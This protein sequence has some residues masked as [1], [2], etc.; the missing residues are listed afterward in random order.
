MNFSYD[1]IQR[2]VY[3]PTGYEHIDTGMTEARPP[4]TWLSFKPIDTPIIVRLNT[5]RSD[6]MALPGIWLYAETDF[7]ALANAHAVDS[8][9]STSLDKHMNLIA[10]EGWEIKGTDP[11]AMQYIKQR[12]A[13]LRAT[14]GITFQKLLTDVEYSLVLFGNAYLIKVPFKSKN[15]VPGMKLTPLKGQKPIGGIFTVHPARLDAV[16]DG[17]GN[18][19]HWAFMVIGA[20]WAT[21]AKD[22]VVQFK[23]NCPPDYTYGQP[24]YLP[25]LEDIRTYRQL[26]WL[27]V[28]LMNRYLHP[29][30]HVRKGVDPSGKHLY[31]VTDAAIQKTASMLES[32]SADGVFV[33][34]PDV[35]ISVKGMESQALRAGEYLDM[36]KDR[37]L[38]GLNTSGPAMGETKAGVRVTADTITASMHDTT[39]MFQR[40]IAATLNSDVIYYWLIEGGFDPITHP[41][42]AYFIYN[43][44]ALDED[45]KKRNQHI[46]EWF[47][48]ATTHEEYRAAIGRQPLTKK[49]IMED[50]YLG[51]AAAI[52]GATGTMLPQNPAQG[53]TD[54]RLRPVKGGGNQTPNTPTST[55]TAQEYFLELLL[56]QVQNQR[57]A[58]TQEGDLE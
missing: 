57:E 45:I 21:F 34:G 1:D 50:T 49:Q 7:W 3:L 5:T 40:R 42:C 29:L 44:V 16:L 55:K 53:N 13:L 20:Q 54:N 10:K 47:S 25:A 52:A 30:V 37:C 39:L 27:T 11:K 17:V 48:G 12:L 2:P 58:A 46:Q 18:L 4:S 15:P 31:Q 35:E 28:M 19:D 23:V 26:E 8:F 9:L 38:T 51:I 36:W 6:S 56:A 32:A 33:T 22:D 43:S 41:D 24:F 14:T